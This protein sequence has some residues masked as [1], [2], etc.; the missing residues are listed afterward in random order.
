[1]WVNLLIKFYAITPKKLP[2]VWRTVFLHAVMLR[3]YL[4]ILRDVIDQLL[5]IETGIVLFKS[6]GLL[7]SPFSFH[8]K[9]ISVQHRFYDTLWYV[10]AVMIWDFNL[11]SVSVESVYLLC[12]FVGI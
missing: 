4:S 10:I 7:L 11:H 6:M 3:H 12:F 1:M 5:N 2:S 9:V 8:E